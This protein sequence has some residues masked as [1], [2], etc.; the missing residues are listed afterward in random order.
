MKSVRMSDIAER[1]GI[2]AVSVSNALAGRSGVSD[3]MRA[4][5]LETARELGYDTGSRSKLPESA[6]SSIGVLCPDHFFGD[7]SFYVG[8]YRAV[9]RECS[10]LGYSALLELISARAEQACELPLLVSEKKVDALI[11][12]GEVSGEY[13]N[14]VLG[15]GLPSVLLDFYN[16]EAS[17]RQDAVLSDNAWGGYLL[18]RHLLDCGRRKI[19]F[20]GSIFATTSIMDRFL[21]YQKAML[22]AGIH[23]PRQW[24]MEDRNEKNE[25]IPFTFP[26]EMPDA[27]VCACDEV[28]FHIMRELQNRGYRVP[29]DVAVAG[30]DDSPFARLTT[31]PMTAY[32]VDVDGMA[33]AT[34]CRIQEKLSGKRSW[35]GS[36]VVSGDLVPRQSSALP[37]KKKKESI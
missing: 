4:K 35:Y 14:K 33:T 11:F 9:A 29:E 31:P 24:R 5:V 30:Y 15:C 28:G 19:A 17:P 20:V 32:R 26:E 3:E 21:G 23:T 18:T 6:G 27:F 16:G 13:L 34:V 8:L 37:R 1:L 12:L 22:M 10:K 7:N 36:V 2:S 25:Y